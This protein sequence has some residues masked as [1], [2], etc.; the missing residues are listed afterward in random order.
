MQKKEKDFK[1]ST[2]LFLLVFLTFCIVKLS[3]AYAEDEKIGDESD[4]SRASSVHLIELY[5]ELGE[6]IRPGDDPALPFAIHSDEGS[7]G[8]CTSCHSYDIVQKGWHFNAADPNVPAG[9]QGQPWIYTDPCTAT[10]IPLSYR[11]WP[12]TYKPEQLGISP[13][14]FTTIFGRQ[15][16]GG[17]PG[18]TPSEDP[19][20][21][22]RQFVSGNLQINCLSC[23]N[24]HPGQDQAEYARQTRLQNF[25][26]APTAACEFAS[27]EGA[28]ID[29]PDIYDWLTSDKISTIYDTNAFDYK[30]R[31][32]FEV[33]G[34]VK[35]DKCYFCHS[36]ANLDNH[37]GQYW[38]ADEDVHL[39]AGL[40]CVDCHRGGPEHDTIRGYEAEQNVSDNPL[41]VVSSCEG[42]HLGTNSEDNPEAG[43][44]GAP[45]PEHAGIPPLH[46]EKLTCTAC[47]SG[48]WPEHETQKIKTARAH[49]IGTHI[50]LKTPD[51]LPHIYS[52]VFAK[53]DQ[54]KIAPHNLFWPAFWAD[55]NGP[56]VAPLDVDTAASVVTGIIHK[57]KRSKT[58]SWPDITHQDL[59]K[60]LKKL[61]SEVEGEP[62]YIAGGKI[63]QLEGP[64][65]IKTSQHPAAGPVLWPLAH[66]VRP[67]AQSLG[68]GDCCDC[69]AT[70]APFFFAGVNVDSP[71]KIQPEDFPKMF[72]FQDVDSGA[73]KIFALTYPLRHLVAFIV[74]VASLVIIA[75]LVLY[76]LKA[77]DCVLKFLTVKG[78]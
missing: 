15:M 75:V 74:L 35:N 48:P 53:N 62:A 5:N 67:A 46:F 6:Q 78:H 25:R 55:V 58:G 45:V 40:D 70:D 29:Q 71:F 76:A 73:V 1:P 20:Q 36:T 38:T 47:H 22:M 24:S 34:K 21:M 42:C 11:P 27:V 37:P 7:G 18:E 8:T 66:N 61:K 49:G 50:V 30:D 17:G 4:G 31:V 41:A 69:H 64:N 2:K 77:L 39:N 63:Y 56:N 13:I 59:K 65:S 28:A 43:R 3:V 68:K 52:P 12:Q 16:P 23:H 26:W 57:A 19:T 72:E 9:R 60:I 54:G 32:L 10:Q 14:Q 51:L 44:L 33:G